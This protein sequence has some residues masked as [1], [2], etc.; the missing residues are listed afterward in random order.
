MVLPD[1]PSH[2]LTLADLSG[3]A[4]AAQGAETR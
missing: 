1:P 4:A 3:R 2:Q